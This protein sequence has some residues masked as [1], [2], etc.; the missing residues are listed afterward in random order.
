MTRALHHVAAAM[1]VAIGAISLLY[2]NPIYQMA[3]PRTVLWA[4]DLTVVT[5]ALAGVG[6]S[7]LLWRSFNQ[8][9]VPKKIWGRLILGFL[10]WTI[11]EAIW[12]YDQLLAAYHLPYPSLAD[13][14][15]IARYIAVAIGLFLR[16]RSLQMRPSKG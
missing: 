9:E 2:V 5:S 15:W 11:G 8:G 6:L 7:F 1:V 4:Y 10:L 16:Y 14:A 3:V 12:S 13:A